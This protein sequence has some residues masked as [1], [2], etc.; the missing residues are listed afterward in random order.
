WAPHATIV[1]KPKKEERLSRTTTTRTKEK[2]RYGCTSI[3][4]TY[5]I[6]KIIKRWN[7]ESK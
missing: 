5:E 1:T 2:G 3:S 6:E 7:H 4:G